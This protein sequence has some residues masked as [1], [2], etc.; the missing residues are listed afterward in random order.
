M[1]PRAADSVAS[2]Y[3]EGTSDGLH[4]AIRE[5]SGR[6]FVGLISITPHHDGHDKEVSYQLLPRYWGSGK[7]ADALFAV[8]KL[9]RDTLDYPRLIA[10]TQLAN[11]ASRRLLTR[12]G[13]RFE[14]MVR[15]CGEDQ[16]IYATALVAG[17][18]LRPTP[19]R[20]P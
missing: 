19:R 1:E 6:T 15:R 8:M 2:R 7:A 20:E 12:V 10:E 17:L 11:E 16:A 9:A 5:R 14:R 13:M 4:W 3:I 18:G